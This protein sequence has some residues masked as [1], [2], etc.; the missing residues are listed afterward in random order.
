[1]A[2]KKST[3]K[4]VKKPTKTRTPKAPPES[5]RRTLPC[6]I[7]KAPIEF[8]SGLDEMAAHWEEEHPDALAKMR[9]QIDERSR[10]PRE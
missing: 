9:R 10:F 2:T 6:K 4:P 1:M 3:K 7:C 5:A 8:T